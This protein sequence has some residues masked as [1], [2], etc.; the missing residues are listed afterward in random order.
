MTTNR[1]RIFLINKRFQLRFTFYVCSWLIALSFAYPL[2]LSN[3][4]DTFMGYLAAD[5]NGPALTQLEK[6]RQDLLMLLML[7]Q[8]VFVSITFIISIFMSHRIAG[9]LYKLS[10]FFREAR[11]GNLEQKISFRKKDYFQELVGEYNDMME[12]IRNRIKKNGDAIQQAVPLLENALQKA[13]SGSGGSG[14][15]KSDLES[16]LTVLKNSLKN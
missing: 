14:E 3:A 13:S 4:F 5:P 6:N 12:S 7:M 9:P 11:D 16:A 8:V 2:I 1:R 10:R 15:S